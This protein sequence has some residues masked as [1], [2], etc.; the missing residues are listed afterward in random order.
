MREP[1]AEPTSNARRSGDRI[2]PLTDFGLPAFLQEVGG[3]IVALLSQEGQ[4]LAANR[5]FLRLAPP[6]D[7]SEPVWDVRALFLNPRFEDLQTLTPHRGDALLLYRGLLRFGCEDQAV[8]SLQGHIY[9]WQQ[10]R[11]LVA[12]DDDVEGLEI[13]GTA[14]LRLNKE[15]AEV[16][17]QLLQP[18]YDWKR[19]EV[20]IRE[21]MTTDPL[22]GVGNRRRLDE[23]L[24]M[25]IERSHRRDFSFCLLIADL[26]YFRGVNDCYG[27]AMGDAVLKR[28]AA[29]LRE[30]SRQ[31]DLVTRCDGDQFMVLLPDTVLESAVVYAERIRQGLERQSLASSVERI[32]ASFGIAM[33]AAGETGADLQRRAAQALLRSKKEGRNRVTQV[34]APGQAA[35]ADVSSC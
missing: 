13:L 2:R 33:L 34:I 6:P 10:D 4:M 20:L 22:T 25:E 18:P 14:V 24:T 26:D 16:Q 1:A 30:H 23:T 7:S 31:S 3:M 35:A 19:N 11:L 21:L 12:A 8:R 27:Q 5:D 32:T 28:F 9:R 29:L 15:I 17:R